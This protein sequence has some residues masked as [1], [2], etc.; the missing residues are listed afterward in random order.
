MSFF[1]GSWRGSYDVPIWV[2]IGGKWLSLSG[3]AKREVIRRYQ[4]RIR[5]ALDAGKEAK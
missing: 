4:K 3:M 2:L 5:T 1:G